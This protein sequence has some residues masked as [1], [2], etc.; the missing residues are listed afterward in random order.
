M[1]T[2]LRLFDG[3]RALGRLLPGLTIVLSVAVL[4]TMMRRVPGL[5]ILSP[6]ML[7]VLIG[8]VL[9]HLYPPPPRYLPGIA[10]AGRRILRFAIVLLGLQLS[11]TQIVAIGVE[12]VLI[13]ACVVTTTFIFITWMGAR[14]GVDSRLTGLLAAGTSICGA[15][16]VTAM[17]TVNQASD[18]DVT[19]A[20]AAVTVFGT[21]LMFL[22]PVAGHALDL[23]GRAFGVWAGASIHEVAQV[24]GAAFQYGNASGEI[25]TVIKLTRVMMLAP[26][27]AVM[28]IWLRRSRS[29]ESGD[30][31]PIAFPLFVLGFIAAAAIN[32]LVSI[33]PDIRAS[34]LSVTTFL[35]SMALA[36][37]GLHVHVSRLKAKGMRPLALGALGTVL[38][39]GLSLGLVMLGNCSG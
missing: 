19:Y 16:A 30:G 28:V 33:P 32:S 29:A 26:L 17:S 4:A 10:F 35:M 5:S 39:T 38:I 31:A 20:M 1:E 22:L 15:S 34:I 8:M 37:L 12:G 13:V 27:V 36:A 7:A 6:L 23:D 9:G 24:T 3:R 14:L 25:G 11:A 18:E 21:I 2:V